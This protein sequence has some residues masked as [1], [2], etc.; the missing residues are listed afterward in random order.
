ME[1]YNHM[2]EFLKIGGT[3]WFFIIA[4][5]LALTLGA[6]VSSVTGPGNLQGSAGITKVSILYCENKICG[7]EWVD[8]K[9]K[10]SVILK[11]TMPEGVS[12]EYSATAVK[13]F[14]AFVVRAA[15]E[16]AMI[17]AGAEVTPAILDS[18]MKTLLGA[19]GIAAATAAAPMI[20]GP[21]LA[22]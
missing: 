6:C 9:E 16:K 13:A 20:L 14:D 3:L 5:A 1:L 15:V 8:G 18:I 21:L 17:K 10:Q 2:L 7:I 11:L 4:V 22:P 12:F 19:S